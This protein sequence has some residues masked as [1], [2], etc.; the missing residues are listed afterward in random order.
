MKPEGI[1]PLKR[2]P[3]RRK[4]DTPGGKGL[5]PLGVRGFYP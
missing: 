4:P 2:M 3:Y 5:I 1:N